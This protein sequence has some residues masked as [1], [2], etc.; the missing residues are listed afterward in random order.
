MTSLRTSRF[1]Y[2]QLLPV[3]TGGGGEDSVGSEVKDAVKDYKETREGIRKTRQ[4]EPGSDE[5]WA[6]VLQTREA[7]SDHMAKEQR[8]D[9]PDFRRNS[10]CK[11]EMRS[12]CRSSGY[13]SEDATGIVPG[14]R[15]PTRTSTEES[16]DHRT[17]SHGPCY[18][19]AST[20]LLRPHS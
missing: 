17:T 3:G 20:S 9:L 12:R 18:E 14:T 1:F 15:T 2:P 8:E 10:D 5:W 13:E 4:Q 11:R 6:A 7:N 16:D 19:L